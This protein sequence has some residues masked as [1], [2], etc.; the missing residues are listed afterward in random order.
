MT[1]SHKLRFGIIGF[2]AFA[3]RAVL[4]AMS[5]FPGVE[6]VALQKRSLPEAEARARTHGV[7][8]A[9]ARADELAAHPDIDAVFI[10]S[11][12]AAHC[13]E[14]LAAA[15]AGKHVL[16]EKPMALNVGEAEQ[17]IAACR[18]HGV[19]LMVG[20]LVR[21][22][23]LVRRARQIVAAGE[24]GTVTYARADF[25]YDGRM[26]RREW[27]H[28]PVVAG[29]GPVVDVGVHCLDT[30]RY[31]LD[32]EVVGAGGVLWPA[33][34]ARRTEETALMGLQFSRGTVGAIFC[35]YASC[36]RR[37][38]LEIVGTEGI[39]TCGD[40]S[41]GGQQTDLTITM[42]TDARPG[43]SCVETFQVPNLI[44]E[45]VAHF[46]RVVTEG[47]IP[48]TPGENGLANQRVIDAVFDR[49]KLEGK[50]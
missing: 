16:V 49:R 45:E 24:L 8:L 28:D 6:V 5:A 41:S 23:P 32:D 37:K 14:T 31:V 43:E 36:V 15:R 35:S 47:E 20:H 29:G 4:P 30:L 48:V 1:S 22:S 17:M 27:L 13:P 50:I 10:V 18:Q 25:A 19:R 21:F 11:A 12:N 38:Q 9:L 40:F 39:I 44:G 7:R 34:T 42:G 46:V 26:S 3:E 33:P 2:G